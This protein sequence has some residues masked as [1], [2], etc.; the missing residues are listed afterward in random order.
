MCDLCSIASESKNIF[1]LRYFPLRCKK[2][3]TEI[4]LRTSPYKAFDLKEEKIKQFVY[5]TK[6]KKRKFQLMTE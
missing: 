6:S 1:L 4:S 2:G 5:N 3:T